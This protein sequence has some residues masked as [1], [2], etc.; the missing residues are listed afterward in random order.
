MII[1]IDTR[2]LVKDRRSEA[3]DFI[4]EVLSRIT[5][6]H[7]AHT[8]IF[9]FDAAYDPSFIFSEN[10]IPV[11]KT[12]LA[13]SPAKWF[14]WYNVKI[15]LVLKKYKAD[16]FI[17][18]DG[19]CSL[20]TNVPQ[21][22]VLN[23]LSFL[24]F[25]FYTDKN[26]LSFSKKFTRRF[27]KKA[28]IVITGAEYLKNEIIKHYKFEPDKIHVL[29]SGADEKLK[30]VSDEEKQSI[31]EKYADGNEYFIYNGLIHPGK[32][33]MN[34]LKAFSAFKKRQKSNMQLLIVSEHE[35]AYKKFIASLQLFRFKNDVKLLA[36]VSFDEAV[37]VTASSYAMIYP[38]FFYNT[39]ADLLTAM[40]VKVPVITSSAGAMPE[41]CGEAAL[42]ADPE[43]FKEIAIRMMDLFRNENLRKELIEK[44]KEQIQK[45]NWD[46]SAKFFWLSLEKTMST[47]Q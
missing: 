31:K 12:S 6:L 2:C 26:R 9:I 10:V 44:G 35:P 11:V 7:K 19:F 33:L 8:F 47:L 43:N 34:L 41:I 39:G 4:Y 36:P 29:Y 17:C 38:A 32:N 28:K 42:Y 15:P 21:C 30:P 23:D 25:P 3:G 27:L 40:K 14:L 13:N 24:N 37:Q 22:L 5:G 45:F 46:S 16:V 18:T 1:A 20:T